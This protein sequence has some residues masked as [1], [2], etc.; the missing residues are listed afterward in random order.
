[1]KAFVS[2]IL[3]AVLFAIPAT[4]ANPPSFGPYTVKAIHTVGSRSGLAYAGY[5]CFELTTM[6]T[7]PA[8]STF[9]VYS[10]DISYESMLAQLISAR[11]NNWTVYVN[12]DTT[13]YVSTGHV[14]YIT[15]LQ[16]N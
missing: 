9:W 5:F 10:Y 13:G 15:G 7:S 12:Y 2:A 16:T 6:P 3:L 1:M 14:G 11:A 8:I 4:G